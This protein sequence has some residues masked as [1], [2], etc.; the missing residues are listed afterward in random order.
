ML[1]NAILILTAVVLTLTAIYLIKLL[2]NINSKK[3]K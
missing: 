1:V 2:F 3:R